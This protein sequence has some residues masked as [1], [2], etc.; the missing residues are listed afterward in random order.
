MFNNS[1]FC[2]IKG[3]PPTNS[4]SPMALSNIVYWR[5]DDMPDKSLPYNFINRIGHRYGRLL[6]IERA[7]NR[8]GETMW[9]C[10]CDC[11][12]K[13]TTSGHVLQKGSRSCGCLQRE[14]IRKLNISRRKCGVGSK[15]LPEYQTWRAMKERCYSKNS[16]AYK[17]YGARGITVCSEWKNDFMAFYRDMSPRPKGL[18]P[19]GK[20]FFL[21][22]DRID[23]NGPYS[24]ENCRW[25]PLGEQNRN[26]R[27]RRR[28]TD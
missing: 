14:H 18:S 27:S 8:N 12:K 1:E 2:S 6:V 10:L 21:T 7:T 16:R 13:I 11:G 26:R 4:R 25:I 24:K 23:N 28:R 9:V 15:C 3:E 22:L 19:N 17:W 20:R 5:Y